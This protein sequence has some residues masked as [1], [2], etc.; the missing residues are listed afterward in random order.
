MET[1]IVF[2]KACSMPWD[3]F[4][5]R[6][7]GVRCANTTRKVGVHAEAGKQSVGQMQLSAFMY[8]IQ[9]KKMAGRENDGVTESRKLRYE[10]TQ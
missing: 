3:R 6:K 9:K 4:Y 1:L 7:V 10:I 2:E 5:D 8:F